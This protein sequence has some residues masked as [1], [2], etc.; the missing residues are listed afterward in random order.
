MSILLTT[1]LTIPLSILMINSI[2]VNNI[3]SIKTIRSRNSSVGTALGYGLD[4]R[5]SRVLLPA[6]DGN[7][8]LRHGVQN[9]SGAHPASYPMGTRASFPGGKAAGA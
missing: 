7:F 1:I 3:D 4:D 6:E 8:S 2:V 9:G 5:V